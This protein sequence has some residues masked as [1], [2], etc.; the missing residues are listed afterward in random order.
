MISSWIISLPF[1]L[2]IYI[3]YVII[4]GVPLIIISLLICRFVFRV[5]NWLK[6][7]KILGLL[8]ILSFIVFVAAIA[9]IP[10]SFSFA[11]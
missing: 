10:G 8:L 3:D 7:F 5:N 11:P 6:V 9:L 1:F 2:A 4:Y